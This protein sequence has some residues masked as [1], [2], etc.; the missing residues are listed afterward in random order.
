MRFCFIRDGRV[1]SLGYEPTELRFLL[2]AQVAQHQVSAVQT[3]AKYVGW[4]VLSTCGSVG[5]GG[6][7]PLGNASSIVMASPNGEKYVELAALS[8][9]NL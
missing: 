9:Y 7:E 1:I 2:M 6:V 5:V 3:L 8:D 4:K